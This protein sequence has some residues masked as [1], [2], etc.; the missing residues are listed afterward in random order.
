MSGFLWWLIVLIGV[1]LGFVA[2]RLY[3]LLAGIVLLMAYSAG[4]PLGWPRYQSVVACLYGGLV[5]GAGFHLIVGYGMRDQVVP[6]IVA[7]FVV[8]LVPRVVFIAAESRYS[9]TPKVRSRV[10]PIYDRPK[11]DT[12]TGVSAW[13]G[14]SSGGSS[15]P[16]VEGTRILWE[17]FSTGE[18]C[19]GGPT[20]GDAIFSNGCAFQGVGPSIIIS[21]D[22]HYAAMTLPSREAWGLL[23]VD[24][25]ARKAY[26][27]AVDSVPWEIDAIRDGVICGRESPL[28]YDTALEI[29]I[30]DVLAVATPETLV[31]DDGWWLLDRPDRQTLPRYPA[32]TLTSRTGMHEL[33]LVPD[34]RPFKRNPFLRFQA[35][36]YSLLLDRSLLEMVVRT[37]R[38]LWIDSA[39]HEGRYLVIDDQVLD[40][41]PA[42]VFTPTDFHCLLL[43]VSG[44]EVALSFGALN[45]S[46]PDEL[47]VEAQ[48]MYR[49]VDSLRAEYWIGST[50]FPYD[51]DQKTYWDT[52]G[53]HVRMRVRVARH[54]R[55][56]I[57]LPTF[58]RTGQLHL[59]SRIDLINRTQPDQWARLTP[60][61]DQ[62]PTQPYAHFHC[63]TACGVDPG[64][65]LA[66]SIWSHCGRYLAVVPAA[67]P[68]AVPDTIRIIDVETA[69]QRDLPG[70]YA[71]PSFIWFESD[72]LDFTCITGVIEH[73]MRGPG[74]STQQRLMLSDPDWI[75]NPYE[76]LF[77]GFESRRD[78]Q[79]AEAYRL[80]LQGSHVDGSVHH[81]SMHYA[82]FGPDFDQA[83]A[84]PPT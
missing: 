54:R 18:I 16:D 12:P 39:E 13:S 70:R 46:K 9:L 43:N 15:I 41:M 14:E 59:A 40:L 48:A 17:F 42:G 73:L 36:E 4:K 65:V 30:C 57:D 5:T 60:V 29:D 75:E 26:F 34:L 58:F 64:V 50:T 31:E 82:L 68:P 44:N 62:D 55:Y 77:S 53:K 21:D 69:T 83:I 23:L 27:P 33:T 45:S 52:Q 2:P 74:Q 51:E 67:L 72:L 38:A 79:R 81:L 84:Q 10:V 80:R 66:E 63:Q 22:G 8:W 76:L 7:P 1:A 6:M 61:A 11:G 37:P 25:R 28:T 49:S 24:L 3:S 56:H 32:V 78:A 35:P 19:M 20:Y 47:T 71:C